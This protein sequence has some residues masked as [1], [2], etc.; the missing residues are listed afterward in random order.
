MYIQICIIWDIIFIQYDY[1]F[2]AIKGSEYSIPTM[3]FD[4]TKCQINMVYDLSN[5]FIAKKI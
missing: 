5:L 4:Y 2:G 1:N 3:V